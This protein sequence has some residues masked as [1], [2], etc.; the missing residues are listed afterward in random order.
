[1]VWSEIYLV[2]VDDVG[3]E[4]NGV[5]GRIFQK[6]YRV[7]GLVKLW[8]IIIHILNSDRHQSISRLQTVVCLGRLQT[9]NRT[10]DQWLRVIHFVLYTVHELCFT[11][12]VKIHHVSCVDVLCDCIFLH[13][14]NKCVWSSSTFGNKLA[15]CCEQSVTIRGSIYD[16]IQF[17]WIIFLQSDD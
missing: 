16:R 9:E 14:T 15:R 11:H 4:H 12:C 1:M 8:R 7:V 3:F 6:C 2:Q 10:D 13:C 5:N 17:I